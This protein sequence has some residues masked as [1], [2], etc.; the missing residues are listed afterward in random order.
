MER[1]TRKY[2]A[3]ACYAPKGALELSQGFN[4]GKFLPRRGLQDSAQGFNPGNP[5]INGSP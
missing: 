4:R 3:S 5:E 2:L 1:L